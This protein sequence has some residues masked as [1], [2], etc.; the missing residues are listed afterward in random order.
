VIGTGTSLLKS[1]ATLQGVSG[2]VVWMGDY[3]ASAA[4]NPVLDDTW[5][6]NSYALFTDASANPGVRTFLQYVPEAQADSFAIYGWA[7]TLAFAEAARAVVAKDGVNGLT[8]SSFLQHGV[9]TLT[10]F[11]ADGL[12]G[13]TNMYEHIPTPCYVVWHLTHG[14]FKRVYPTKAGTFDCQTSNLVTTKAD[15]VGG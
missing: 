5:G 10:K 7:A 13:T 4:K 12:I 14:R 3:S 2:P 15:Y 6:S 11:D 9:Q 1:E 8:R